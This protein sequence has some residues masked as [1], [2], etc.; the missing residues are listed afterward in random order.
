MNFMNVIKSSGLLL[1]SE[2]NTE[3]R[4]ILGQVARFFKARGSLESGSWPW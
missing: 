2:G 3:F 1:K 4:S